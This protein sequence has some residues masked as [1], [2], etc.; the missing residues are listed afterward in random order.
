M[1]QSD[2]GGQCAAERSGVGGDRRRRVKQHS[3]HLRVGCIV[4]KK[5][6]AYPVGHG[7]RTAEEWAIGIAHHDQAPLH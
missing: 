6:S 5:V 7:Q 2:S 3:G 1:H 4:T